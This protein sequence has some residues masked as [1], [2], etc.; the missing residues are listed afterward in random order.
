MQ[1]EPANALPRVY[2]C[3]SSHHD[4]GGGEISVC[5]IF[6]TALTEAKV[7][8]ICSGAQLM[9]VKPD[10]NTPRDKNSRAGRRWDGAL[11]AGR[12]PMWG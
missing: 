1:R 12:I 4:T 2:L 9:H 7:S 8:S 11:L 5:L 3:T 10:G 6:E